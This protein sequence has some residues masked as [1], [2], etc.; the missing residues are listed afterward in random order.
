MLIKKLTIIACALPLYAY[1]VE[2][3]IDNAVCQKGL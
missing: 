1:A 3:E 2:N